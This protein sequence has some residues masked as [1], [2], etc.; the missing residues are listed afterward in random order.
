MHMSPAAAATLETKHAHNVCIADRSDCVQKGCVHMSGDSVVM[1]AVLTELRKGWQSCI[2]HSCVATCR[3]TR[4]VDQRKP[5]HSR[6]S[7]RCSDQRT[8]TVASQARCINCHIEAR[9]RAFDVALGRLRARLRHSRVRK[10]SPASHRLA[11]K[12]KRSNETLVYI[13]LGFI[14]YVRYRLHCLHRQRTFKICSTE[15]CPNSAWIWWLLRR[16]SCRT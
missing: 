2:T 16:R 12:L 5:S 8:N 11:T 4:S 10:S 1:H 15:P 6:R 3:A 7:R 9:S 13:I 14:W